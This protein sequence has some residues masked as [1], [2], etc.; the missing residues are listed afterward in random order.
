MPFSIPV[1]AQSWLRRGRRICV[2]NISSEKLRRPNTKLFLF[3]LFP[4]TLY[5]KNC[6]C[7][8]NPACQ[9]KMPAHQG[10][11]ELSQTK[12]HRPCA[13]GSRRSWRWHPPSTPG[14]V[15]PW[16]VRGS[17]PAWGAQGRCPVPRRPGGPQRFHPCST[18]RKTKYSL[19]FLSLKHLSFLKKSVI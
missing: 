4:P 17:C 5:G 15:G 3:F 2:L 12:H 18:L 10:W 8:V 13:G 9:V 6:I 11:Q 7:L 1:L 16:G 19:L 14:A